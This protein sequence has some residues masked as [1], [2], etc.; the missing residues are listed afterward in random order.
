MSSAGMYTLVS[1]HRLA[2]NGNPHKLLKSMVSHKGQELTKEQARLPSN[3]KMSNIV[4]GIGFKGLVH[5]KLLDSGMNTVMLREGV[6]INDQE[7]R[8]VLET[9]QDSFDVQ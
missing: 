6:F 8:E 1:K 9:C 5:R 7:L 4:Q 3:L 2:Y